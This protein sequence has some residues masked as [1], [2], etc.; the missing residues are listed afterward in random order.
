MEAGTGSRQRLVKSSLW[1]DGDDAAFALAETPKELAQLVRDGVASGETLIEVTLANES[2]DWNG[3]SAFIGP[4]FVRSITP[5][6][7][8]MNSDAED[9]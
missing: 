1:L 2:P 8:G 9:D 5:P 7:S 6:M 3:R 4:K